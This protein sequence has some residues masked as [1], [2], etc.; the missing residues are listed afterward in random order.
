[1][2]AVDDGKVIEAVDGIPDQPR[3]SF[4]PV[5][6]EIADGNYVI[7]R[8]ARGVY[9]GYAHLIPGTVRVRAGDGVETGQVLGELGNSGNSDG[10]HLHFQ[11]MNR[12]SL[13]A[14]EGLPFVLRRFSLRGIVPSLAISARPTRTRRRFPSSPRVRAPTAT[15]ARSGS[16]SSTSRADRTTPRI[17][18]IEAHG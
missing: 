15:V 14:S 9:V 4:T 2:L 10:P 7:L 16:T 18:I 8:I 11:V 13:L 17:A 1:V 5:G 12:P 3:D 6:L